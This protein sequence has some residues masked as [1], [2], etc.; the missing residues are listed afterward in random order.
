MSGKDANAILIEATFPAANIKDA[1]EKAAAVTK[2]LGDTTD[3]AGNSAQTAAGKQDQLA[4]STK[5]A[6]DSAAAAKSTTDDYI[7]VLGTVPPDKRTDFL[8]A[9]NRGDVDAANAILDGV[10]DPRTAVINVAVHGINIG[11]QIGAMVRAG[12]AAGGGTVV[13]QTVFM[14]MGSQGPAVRRAGARF[15]NGVVNGARR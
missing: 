15:G 8:A 9:V 1:N 11:A 5:A 10:A 4:A 12:A 14:P 13:S 3:A 7:A 6:G 2:V